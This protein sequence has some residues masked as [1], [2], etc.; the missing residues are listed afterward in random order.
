M[1]GSVDLPLTISALESALSEADPSAALA[2]PRILRRVIKQHRQ[3]SG[4]GLKVPHRKTYAI[5]AEEL[6][7]IVDR[8]EL[9]IP[10]QAPLPANVILLARPDAENL[11]SLT[12]GEALGK[13]WRLLFH[14]RV[15]VALERRIAEG[16][17]N[18][19]VA[20]DRIERIGRAAFEEAKLVL[21][22][23]DILLPPIDELTTYVEFVA[24]YW[25]LRFFANTLLPRYFPTL[26]PSGDVDRILSEDL[27]AAAL[28]TETRL[29]GAPLPVPP[30]E[31]MEDDAA[32]EIEDEELDVLP[33]KASERLCRRLNRRAER[34]ATLGNAVRAA[35]LRTRAARHVRPSLA[36]RATAAARV[37]LNRLTDRLQAALGFS[38]RDRRRWSRVL[39]ALLGRSASGYWTRESRTLY[40]LQ[41]V[42][43]DFERDVYKLDLI[44]WIISRGRLPIKR[45]LPGQREVL[46]SKHL[47]VALRRSAKVRLPERDRR[48]LASLLVGEVER[49]EQKLRDRFRPLV[50]GALES[51]ALRP[52][53]LPEKVARQKLVEE[54]LDRVVADGFLG[55]S[56]LRDAI[57]RNQLKL[58]DLS[59]G[60]EFFSGDQLLRAD[61]QLAAT[62]DGVYHRGEVYLRL[63]Q[64]LSSL[65]FGAPLGRLLVRYV[66]LPYGGAYVILEGVKHLVAMV[67]RGP[68]AASGPMAAEHVGAAGRHV[69]ILPGTTLLLA[70]LIVGT[71]L[72]GLMHVQRFREVCLET[73]RGVYRVLRFAAIEA[74]AWLMRLPWVQRLLKSRYYLWAA[75]YVGKPLVFTALS[76]AA[77]PPLAPTRSA[78]LWNGAW[79]FVLANLLVNSRVGRNAEEVVTDWAV[80]GWEHFRIRI[81]KTLVQSV[82]E[83]FNRVVDT[84]DRFLYSV[85]EWLRFRSGQGRLAVVVKS[86][87]GAIWFFVTYVVRF[88]INLLIEPQINPVKHFPVVT[89]SHKILLSMVPITHPI[90]VGALERFVGEAAAKTIFW[91][92]IFVLPGVFGFL[93]WELKENWRLYQANRPKALAPVPVGAHG[94]TMVRLLR[95]GFHS[96]TLPKLYARLRRA[97]RRAYWTGNWKTSRKYRDAIR[98]VE[99]EIRSLIERELLALLSQSRRFGGRELSLGRLKTGAGSVR[100]ELCCP[101]QPDAPLWMAL[102]EHTGWLGARVI[103]PGWS[104]SLDDAAQQAL[105]DA[106]TGLYKIAGV[107]LIRE[108]IESALEPGSRYEVNESG[109]IV[110]SD[111]EAAP[112]F[113]DLRK[114][115]ESQAPPASFAPSEPAPLDLEQMAFFASPVTW[116]LWVEVWDRDQSGG[117]YPPRLVIGAHLLPAPVARP[118]VQAT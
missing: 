99:R 105:A 18:A 16:T 100:F 55:M 40:D 104:G 112:T 27:D 87:L 1:A 68:A 9:D 88:A 69:D 53:N 97:D 110:W 34:A 82:M 25:E 61:R 38:E 73:L 118:A 29:P 90:V 19:A 39:L 64:R 95:P 103:E 62:L 102:E 37:D 41:K 59:G 6:L 12:S 52:K 43:T 91:N 21:R 30:A 94:E 75:R 106:L 48:R 3:I 42:C 28:L 93:V 31:E 65:A 74:P 114:L 13:Y 32:E 11:A 70:V 57:S 44:E 92:G 26:P 76:I 108:Q 46:M 63:P 79:I 116:E 45:R 89:V 115:H 60:E 49:A 33:A 113:Y 17:L 77:F 81:L 58:P 84:L 22:Q 14:I 66:A 15:H 10:A 86:V 23:E 107:E 96:G 80:R 56:D 2:P 8:D 20:R 109:L 83:F 50:D 67:V 98:R 47:R 71:F 54:L 5:A 78:T 24:V 36:A 117:R 35:I 7:K 51:V 111:A 4:I 72:L 101:E 85:D